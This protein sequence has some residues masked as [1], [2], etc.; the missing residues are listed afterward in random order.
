[1]T[2]PVDDA[3][4][5][6]DADRVERARI[7]ARIG[8]VQQVVSGL[9]EDLKRAL[10]RNASLAREHHE[11]TE[12]LRQHELLRVQLR[13]ARDRWRAE[14]ER[15]RTAE[16]ERDAV[17]RSNAELTAQCERL[18]AELQRERAAVSVRDEQVAC[19]ER[20]VEQLEAI[21][22]LLRDDGRPR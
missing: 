7:D 20:Q 18:R 4:T 16:S 1:M 3:Q 19:L 9:S 21:V 5:A 12:I 8:D 17:R 22:A 14:S 10:A 13:E 11:L 2:E 6:V 15:T